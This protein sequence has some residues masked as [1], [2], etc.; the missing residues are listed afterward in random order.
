MPNLNEYLGSIMT[1]VTNARVISDLQTIRVAEEYANHNLLKHFSIPR[2]RIDDVEM[3]IPVGMDAQETNPEPYIDTV[4]KTELNNLLYENIIKQLGITRIN[5]DVKS[6]F[7]Q[8]INKYIE[9]LTATINVANYKDLIFKYSNLIA[10]NCYSIAIKYG[11]IKK[12]V[13][14]TA[15]MISPTIEKVLNSKISI[16]QR[17]DTLGNL[18]VIVEAN[19]LREFAPETLIYIKLKISEDGMEWNRAENSN[20]DIIT[21]LLPE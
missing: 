9:D 5:A 6:I 7:E 13:K 2:M 3:T 18:N 10:E 1:S 15:A 21:K 14:I 4:N 20:G 16:V 19:R 11:L 12:T 8:E 17:D